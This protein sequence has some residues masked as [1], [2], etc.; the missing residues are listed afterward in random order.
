MIRAV[1]QT[2]ACFVICLGGAAALLFFLGDH[3]LGLVCGAEY[4]S[5]GS[6]A[7][8]L[9][10]GMLT[11]SISIAFQNGL[12]ALGKPHGFLF[13]E[14]SYCVTAVTLAAILIPRLELVGAALSLVVAGAVVSIVTI[15]TLVWLL[16]QDH[17]RV[18][19]S[20]QPSRASS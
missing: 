13:G 16:K 9:S 7:A 19:E 3:L 18:D 2:V 10:L 5:Y 6:I 8:L 1:L 20:L 17:K 12:A 15:A 11:M 4:A 14:L